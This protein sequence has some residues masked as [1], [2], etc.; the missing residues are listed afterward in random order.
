MVSSLWHRPVAS[1][2]RSS[3]HIYR[4]FQ[5]P[6]GRHMLEQELELIEQCRREYKGDLMVQISGSS[7][8]LLGKPSLKRQKVVLSSHSPRKFDSD[9][10]GYSW[11]V[12]DFDKIPLSEGSVDFLVLHHVLEFSENPHAVLRDA[13]RVLAPQ[14]HLVVVCFNPY[15]LFG[16]RKSMQLALRKEIPWAHHGLS[17][18]RMSDWMHLMSCEPLNTGCGFYGFPVQ[19]L[20]LMSW[21]S[22]LDRW[23][24]YI[25]VPCGGFYVVHASKDVMTPISNGA[26][27]RKPRLL[28][29]PA[30]ASAVRSPINQEGGSNLRKMTKESDMQGY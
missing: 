13:V 11:V 22:R 12:S 14:G 3:V 29:F 17:A 20:K 25:G 6:V 7:R 19:S 30:V 18:R 27:R 16:V 2:R 8:K 5:T 1:M 26:E 10:E 15:S 23:L 9:L 4:W 24:S 21:F 28:E